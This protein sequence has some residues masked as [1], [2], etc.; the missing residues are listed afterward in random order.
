MDSDLNFPQTV[1]S[2]AL[3]RAAELLGGTEALGVYLG[4]TPTK[5][6]IWMRGSIAPPGD[7]FVRV[8]DLLLEHDITT[9]HEKTDGGHSDADQ[10]NQA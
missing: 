7:V 3:Q 9:L 2:R 5:L 10:A 1:H 8:V 6:G 4:V